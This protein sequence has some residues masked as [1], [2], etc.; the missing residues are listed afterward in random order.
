[1]FIIFLIIDVRIK[2]FNEILGIGNEKVLQGVKIT[3]DRIRVT[4]ERNN[5]TIGLGK[6]IKFFYEEWEECQDECFSR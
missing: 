5:K 2:T 3:D 1:M 6:E 4:K